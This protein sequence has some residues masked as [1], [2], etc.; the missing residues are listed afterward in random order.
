M[1]RLGYIAVPYLF[2]MFLA[3]AVV[4]GVRAAIKRS[5]ETRGKN[6]ILSLYGP[7]TL[8]PYAH[9]CVDRPHL[10][11]PACAWSEDR[12][13]ERGQSIVEV[14]LVLTAVIILA[15]VAYHMGMHI[16]EALHDAFEVFHH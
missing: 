9:E 16:R 3:F 7:P 8:S 14:C 6:K 12:N 4:D 1:N 2:L 10:T 5:R 11:C 13:K 15:T